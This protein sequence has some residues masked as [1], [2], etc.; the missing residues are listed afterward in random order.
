MKGNLLSFNVAESRGVISGE[1]GNRYSF[2]GSE[3]EEEAIPRKGMKLDFIV[4][5]GEATE[6]YL[7]A[8]PSFIEVSSE[9]W[10]KSSDNKMLAGVCAGLADKF[11]VSVTGMRVSMFLLAFFFLLPLA[12][13][14]VLWLMLSA[15][16]T[17]I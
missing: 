15:K 13:Y 16:P 8:G 11:S 10:Y 4:A 7:V 5:D 12:I 17:R 3:W 9:G 1:D 2:H 6:I 14:I